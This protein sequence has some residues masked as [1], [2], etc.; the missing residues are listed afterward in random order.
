MLD[1]ASIE[2]SVVVNEFGRE[3]YERDQGWFVH[4]VAGGQADDGERPRVRQARK[5]FRGEPLVVQ[6]HTLWG[7]EV[8]TSVIRLETVDGKIARLRSYTFCP[9]AIREVAEE[10]GLPLGPVFYSFRP[11][12]AAWRS[13]PTAAWRG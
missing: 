4:S 8:M 1:S 5:E 7:A 11:F 12:L 13:M 9:D 10:L 2:M 6:L 3:G